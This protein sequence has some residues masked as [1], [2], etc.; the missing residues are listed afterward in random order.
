ADGSFAGVISAAIL[1]D[2]FTRL[3]S[4]LDLGPGGIALIR[5]ADLG[6]VT[7]YPPIEGPAG[8]IGN[9]TASKELTD[10]VRSRQ[11]KGTF[12]SGGTA[13]GVERTGS[14]RILSRLPFVVIAGM[15]SDHYLVGWRGDVRAAIMVVGVFVVVLSLSGLLLWRIWRHLKEQRESFRMLF[16]SHP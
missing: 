5:D 11:P 7:R 3:L 10:L 14:Y 13:D 1:V 6:M 12:H 9:R 4:V 16:D 8:A 15:S 2:H